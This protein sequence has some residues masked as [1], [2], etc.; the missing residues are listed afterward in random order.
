MS[1][2]AP[3]TKTGYIDM[4]DLTLIAACIDNFIDGYTLGEL[5]TGSEHEK[6][7]KTAMSIIEGIDFESDASNTEIVL[8]NQALV[9]F[10]MVNDEDR[11]YLQCYAY[12]MKSILYAYIMEF[13]KANYYFDKITNLETNIT[14]L[15]RR[16]IQN[17]QNAIPDL[18]QATDDMQEELAKQQND[19]QKE[20]AKQQKKDCSNR[21]LKTMITFGLIIG[22]LILVANIILV[23]QSIG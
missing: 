22:V 7:F 14:T 20:L 9:Y 19:M 21:K 6:E 11:L 5:L 18:K 15:R 4:V 17:I 13:D 2:V 10:S 3:D 1:K 23:I 12:Y 16:E 8:I